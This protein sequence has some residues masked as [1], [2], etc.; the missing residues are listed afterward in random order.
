VTLKEGGGRTRMTV[1]V[2]LP[3]AFAT[4]EMPAGF[5]DHVEAGWRDTVDRLA[6][7]LAGAPA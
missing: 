1:H 5:L 7:E 3:A 6:A 2:E 4:A